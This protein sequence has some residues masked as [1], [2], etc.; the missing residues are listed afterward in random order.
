LVFQG[1]SESDVILAMATLERDMQR[2][3]IKIEEK[4]PYVP[5][6]QISET[7][8]DAALQ[9]DIGYV[10]E[11]PRIRDVD[12]LSAVYRL[13]RGREY[14]CIEECRAIFVTTNPKLVQTATAFFASYQSQSAP[15]ICI[16]DHH[17]TNILWLKK[18]MLLPDLPKKQMMADAYAA[19]HPS[20]ELWRKFLAEVEKLKRG[21]TITGDDYLLLRN[22]IEIK[23]HLMD[24]TLGD[25]EALVE[26]TVAEV[27]A[28]YRS[29]LISGAEAKQKDAEAREQ[30]LEINLQKVSDRI[31]RCAASVASFARWALFLIFAAVLLAGSY[32]SY[33][34]DSQPALGVFFAGASVLLLI[35]S[36]VSLIQ[37]GTVRSLTRTLEG[38]IRR[39]LIRILKR[40]ILETQ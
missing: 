33:M 17:L 23:S 37:G 27:L 13:R 7:D 29:N 3:R 8:L 36:V 20:P 2:L 22:S 16:S 5:E 6:Y 28:A 18:P 39:Y 21:D 9:R 15:P 10:H 12:S 19:M 25:E 4:P 30:V 11:L 40:L 14:H 38:K 1:N 26:G 32:A 24:L 34:S 35:A 31:E